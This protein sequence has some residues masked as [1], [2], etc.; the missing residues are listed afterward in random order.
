MKVAIMDVKDQEDFLEWEEA[1]KYAKPRTY[2][3]GSR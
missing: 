1:S 2:D 3:N